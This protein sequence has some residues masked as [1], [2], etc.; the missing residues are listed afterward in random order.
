[1]YLENLGAQP[2]KSLGAQ[3]GGLVS[4][5]GEEDATLRKQL[6]KRAEE[7]RAHEAT[8]AVTQAKVSKLKTSYERVCAELAKA[9]ELLADSKEASATVLDGTGPEGTKLG[10]RLKNL[11]VQLHEAINTCL[12]EHAHTGT[13]D[14]WVN[15]S[16][17][18]A[19][20]QRRAPDWDVRN[21]GVGKK[22]GLSGLLALPE[23]SKLFELAR[24][25][26][27]KNQKTCAFS[28]RF[29][30]EEEE[31]KKTQKKK[32]KKKP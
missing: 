15:I 32:K 16:K 4:S 3:Q 30:K 24:E 26:S 6:A 9:T 5:G 10:G 1:M 31:K 12:E 20:L 8:L 25:K 23:V 19:V 29:R 13:S 27:K 28:V 17:L 14:G 11:D 2:T 22:A 18:P 21:Y 7:A